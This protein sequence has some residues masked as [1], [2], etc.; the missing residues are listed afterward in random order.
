MEAEWLAAAKKEDESA[1]LQLQAQYEPM[2]RAQVAWAVARSQPSL[3]E[4][5][6]Q[7]AL[8]AFHRAIL[9]Y[10]A[11]EVTFGLYAKICVKNRLRS[12]LRKHRRQM[13]SV[14]AQHAAASVQTS[15]SLAAERAD[16][17]AQLQA[18]RAQLSPWESEVLRHYLAGEKPAQIARSL[19]RPP[20]AVYN[21]LLRIRRKRRG[22]S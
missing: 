17:S 22:M 2:L 1:F 21:A 3:L 4:D 12:F 10:T 16:Y 11:G 5:C 15:L 13:A 6:R 7:E 19:C 8:V 18:L 14:A 20:K 9:T